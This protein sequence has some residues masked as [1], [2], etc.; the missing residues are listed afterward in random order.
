MCVFHFGVVYHR[1]SSHCCELSSHAPILSYLKPHAEGGLVWASVR[2]VLT[3]DCLK[4]FCSFEYSTVVYVFKLLCFTVV[5][6]N[7]FLTLTFRSGWDEIVFMAPL[8]LQR[9]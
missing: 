4:R 6:E 3:A 1:Q 9:L 5:N 2:T 7:R 8:S